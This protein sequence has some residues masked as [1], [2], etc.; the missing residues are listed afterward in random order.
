MKNLIVAVV[1]AATTVAFAADTK[2]AAAA[3]TKP[4]AERGRRDE[5]RDEGPR[6]GPGS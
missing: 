1:I 6:G 4:A 3:E 2:P 5:D